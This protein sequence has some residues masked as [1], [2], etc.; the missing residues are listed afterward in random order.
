MIHARTGLFALPLLFPGVAA[1]QTF[2]AGSTGADGALTF[3]ADAGTIEFDPTSYEP[4]LDADQDNVYHFT[5]VTIPAGTTVRLASRTLPEG[6]PVV[7]RVSGAVVIEGVLDLN[8]DDGHDWDEPFAPSVPGAGG[9][10]G[11]VA[12]TPASPPTRGNGPGGGTAATGFHGGPGA[13]RI[14]GGGNS[15]PAVAPY[16]NDFLLPLVGGS[17]GGGGGSLQAAGGGAGGGAIV[18]A[19]STSIRITGQV[20]ANGGNSGNRASVS[21]H[22]GGGGSGGAIRLIAPV[23]EGNGALSVAGGIGSV[24]ASYGRIRLEAFRNTSSFTIT[25]VQALVQPAAPGLVE[26]PPSAPAIKVVRVAGVAVATSPT[27][28]FQVPDVVIDAP[29]AVTI[30]LEARFVP[31]GTVLNLTFQPETGTPFTATS[32]ALTGTLEQS[33]ATA[34]VQFPHGPTRVFVKAT[35]T[36]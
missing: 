22:L 20:R 2:D 5:A 4:R 14:E 18:I 9:Y 15:L 35:W 28:S 19:S 27:G 34:Q 24:T 21:F 31:P 33:T 7:W 13:H 16:G 36:P 8:G 23:L 11:G 10:A 6:R 26:L 25:P 32:S 3:A 1:A 30:E 29:G 17:G 12:Q